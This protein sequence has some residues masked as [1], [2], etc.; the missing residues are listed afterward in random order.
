MGGILQPGNMVVLCKTCNNQKLDR[1]PNLFYSERDLLRVSQLLE[2]EKKVLE[3]SWD[4]D[5][6]NRDPKSYFLSIGVH[7]ETV[8]KIFEDPEYRYYIE[9]RN[10]DD[11]VTIDLSDAANEVMTA[12]LCKH[13]EFAKKPK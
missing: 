11:C 9:P 6:Y 10:Q 3:F 13:P 2:D 7:E 12:F 4:W 1:D 5:F 8:R